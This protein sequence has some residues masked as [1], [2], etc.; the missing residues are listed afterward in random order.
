MKKIILLLALFA[1][2]CCVSCN[3]DAKRANELIDEYAQKENLLY[4]EV[5]GMDVF[6]T[7]EEQA[8]IEAEGMAQVYQTKAV[9]GEE[10]GFDDE[11][12]EF[13]AIRMIVRS[14]ILR[15]KL[16]EEQRI[17]A[18]MYWEMCT[19]HAKKEIIESW[20]EKQTK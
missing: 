12:F 7:D 13:E 10:W 9:I 5:N 8:Y 15:V 3:S 2:I 17:F 14:E 18:Q 19:Y 16:S 20:L 11:E 6:F 4:N 1:S